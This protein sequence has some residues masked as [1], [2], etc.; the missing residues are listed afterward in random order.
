MV[1]DNLNAKKN[2]FKYPP[3]YQSELSKRLIS[4][5]NMSQ[6]TPKMVV[7]GWRPRLHVE[8]GF[9]QAVH[10]N[11]PERLFGNQT[12]DATNF[13]ENM[14]FAD[15]VRNRPEFFLIENNT[16]ESYYD[17]T[18]SA[19]PKLKNIYSYFKENYVYVESL[20]DYDIF[21]RKDLE[22]WIEESDL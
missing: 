21:L 4:I 17:F 11:V 10:Q 14:Y 1:P 13:S 8:T 22:N 12:Q 6:K 2:D 18:I 5:G 3:I 16:Q 7:F 9:Y 19:M 15:L 20:E